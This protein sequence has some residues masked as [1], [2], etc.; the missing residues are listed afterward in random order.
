MR[1]QLAHRI[2]APLV[3]LLLMPVWQRWA[4][5]PR[6]QDLP[7]IYAM[8]PNADRVLLIG[9]AAVQGLGVTSHEIAFGGHLARQL[10]ASTGRGADVE[11]VGSLNL[12]VQQCT[13]L[14][15]ATDLGRFDAVVM[16]LGM[17]E[18]MMLTPR[19]EW[20]R[21]LDALF[22]AIARAAPSTLTT[23]MVGIPPLPLIVNLPKLLQRVIGRKVVR[24]N[25][26]TRTSVA[27][28][29]GLTFV[30]FEANADDLAG[31]APKRGTNLYETWA[32]RIVPAM[33][34]V[35]NAAS[36]DPRVH[37]R[38]DE[39]DRQHALDDLH[40]LDTPRDELFDSVT[41]VARDLFGA[42]GAAVTF[43]DRERQWIK[44]AAGMRKTSTPRDGSF[45]GVTIARDELFV[46]EDVLADARFASHPWVTGEEQVRFYAGYPLEAPDGER[47]GALCIVDTQPR[48]FTA[49]D[50]SLLRE[51]A[52]R[53][54]STLWAVRAGTR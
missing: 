34:P 25:A 12:T 46:V 22:D 19:S 13:R 5:L 23:L 4:A 15:E 21:D 3:E 40:I 54:Q 27:G 28:R 24:L 14:V 42:S 29:D 33:L 45:C 39:S 47:V 18:A 10:S 17:R 16:L 38:I 6:A 48:K 50:A 30:Q 53:V 35:L 7:H 49:S 1:R 51:L 8:G 31:R 9:G 37:A 44:S 2:A 11:V 32:G 20:R 41:R 52:L 26:L 43:I 36:E